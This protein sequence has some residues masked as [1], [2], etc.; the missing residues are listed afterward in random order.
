VCVALAALQAGEID[1]PDLPGVPLP[2]IP[3]PGLARLG[4]S[5][6]SCGPSDTPSTAALLGGDG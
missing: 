4:Q 5:L 6:T 3:L 2:N 1:L